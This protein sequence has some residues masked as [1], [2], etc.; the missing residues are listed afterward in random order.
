[1]FVHFKFVVGSIVQ[2]YFSL[3]S[4]KENKRGRRFFVVNSLP[5]TITFCHFSLSLYAHAS[6]K[7][8]ICLWRAKWFLLSV[9]LFPFSHFVSVVQV[10]CLR[11]GFW[12]AF[13]WLCLLS[14]THFVSL[15]FSWLQ[16][17]NFS[18]F[19]SFLFYFF[20]LCLFSHK[21]RQSTWKN[22]FI[23][24]TRAYKLSE[25]PLEMWTMRTEEKWKCIYFQTKMDLHKKKHTYKTQN[26]HEVEESLNNNSNN[27]HWWR[28]RKSKWCKV[29]FTNHDRISLSFSTIPFYS[30]RFE[31][32]WFIH[33]FIILC[34]VSWAFVV[35]QPELTY[36]TRTHTHTN[37]ELEIELASCTKCY[38]LECV[39]VS[40]K[41]TWWITNGVYASHSFSN[42]KIDVC[43]V[44]FL[45]SRSALFKELF[46]YL[47]E[48]RC[49][50]L[51]EG[52]AFR[53]SL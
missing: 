23:L 5:Y 42:V 21:S 24:Y 22:I 8:F 13:V 20:V 44:I 48:N 46:V 4:K 52:N 40:C 28:Q 19:F 2:K 41:E 33:P 32:I 30:V 53:L 27:T 49:H 7:W 12:I 10:F 50:G 43:C 37:A 17:K 29:D 14:F 39:C 38:C 3:F 47:W 26:S 6:I 16:L 31:S 36:T 25:K 9:L 15:L 35:F 51:S 1:M 11:L 34:A 45:S 18:L